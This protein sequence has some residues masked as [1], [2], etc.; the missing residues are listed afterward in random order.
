MNSK[1]SKT[2]IGIIYLAIGIY[3]EFWKEFYPSCEKFFCPDAHKG[4]EVFTDSKRLMEQNISNVTFH[5]VKNKGFIRNV[6]A[7]S[8]CICHI[9]GKLRTEYDYIFFMNGNFKNLF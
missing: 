3:D 9:S 5:P 2:R 6:S 1:I 7:K 8:E 4:Y